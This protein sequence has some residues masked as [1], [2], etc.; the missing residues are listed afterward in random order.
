MLVTTLA[1]DLEE[2]EKLIDQYLALIVRVSKSFNPPNDTELEEYIQIGKIALLKAIRTH[3][4]NRSKFIT[5][6]WNYIKWDIIRYLSNKKKQEDITK[7]IIQD[8]INLNNKDVDKIWEWI[9]DS[10]SKE[11]KEI[12]TLKFNGYSFNNINKLLG[13]SK[14]KSNKLFHEAIKKI[15]EANNQEKT[16]TI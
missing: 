15:K 4:P 13:L 5:L 10:I 14:G 3:D 2:E 1:F 9:P 12:I 11:E 16:N 6:A 7:Q 8:N